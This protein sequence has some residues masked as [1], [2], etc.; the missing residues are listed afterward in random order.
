LSGNTTAA[1]EGT[2]TLNAGALELW[3]VDTRAS[4][5]ALGALE[6]R[7]RLLSDREH[8]R[9]AEFADRAQAEEWLAAHITLRIVL[10]RVTGRTA[11]G[12]AFTRPAGGKPQLEGRPVAFSLAHV[13]GAALI[14]IAPG[15][16]V[17]VDLERARDVRVRE[18]R[19][20]RVE[21]AAAALN[22]ETPLPAAGEAR[23]LQAWVRLEAFAKAEG[24]GIGRL[25]TRLGISGE[26]AGSEAAFRARIDRMLGATQVA[27][28][29]DVPLE[30]GALFAAVSSGPACA[31]FKVFKLPTG[32]SALEALL[33]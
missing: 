15:G 12:A 3:H 20:S 13:P 7:V 10:E 26:A 24:T 31:P 9:A 6:E 18:P 25:L 2:P 32:K 16:I 21:A 27:A 19:R 23:F 30:E 14:A 29:R 33:A 1:V 17:G 28:T 5:A 11:R 4:G 22:R 8:E